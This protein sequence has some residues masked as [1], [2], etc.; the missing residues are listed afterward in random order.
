MP[1]TGR[2]AR[3]APGSGALQ[4]FCALHGF[5]PF[6][7]LLFLAAHLL[8]GFALL[9][10]GALFLNREMKLQGRLVRRM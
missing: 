4:G 1:L 9:G 2:E 8:Q 7:A 5:A 3:E 6:I 10:G